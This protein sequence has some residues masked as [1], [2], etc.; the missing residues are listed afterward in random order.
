MKKSEL[1]T[2]IKECLVEENNRGTKYRVTLEDGEISEFYSEEDADTFASLHNGE[3]TEFQDAEAVE[4]EVNEYATHGDAK[5]ASLTE[6]VH[7]WDAE[8]LN[9]EIETLKEALSTETDKDE[10]TALQLMIDDYQIELE[11]LA[12]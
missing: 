1:K 3:V 8:R 12:D 5:I 11:A 2:L 6:E 4:E 7:G 9:K 10:A